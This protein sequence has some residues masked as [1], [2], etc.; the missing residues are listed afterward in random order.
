MV[1]EF[2]A[3]TEFVRTA[4]NYLATAKKMR[5]DNAPATA[6]KRLQSAGE[7]RR[8]AWELIRPVCGLCWLPAVRREIHRGERY[9]FCGTC[10]EPRKHYFGK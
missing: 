4:R 9:A 3:A 6:A 10:W 7:Y 5:E 1:A 8:R 2:A